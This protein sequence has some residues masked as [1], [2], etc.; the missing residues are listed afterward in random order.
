VPKWKQR[1][2]TPCNPWQA[3]IGKCWPVSAPKSRRFGFYSVRGRCCTQ[4]PGTLVIFRWQAF[5]WCQDWWSCE[6][7]IKFWPPLLARLKHHGRQVSHAMN[8]IMHLWN[9]PSWWSY[10]SCN[11][12]WYSF[13]LPLLAR[14]EQHGHHV[15]R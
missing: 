9:I 11:N 13:W 5:E 10:E 3:V 12:I 14:L 2:P 7:C 15:S 6:S 4:F 1:L 8:T